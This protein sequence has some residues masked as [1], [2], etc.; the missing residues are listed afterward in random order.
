MLFL[1]SSGELIEIIDIF[2]WNIV[3]MWNCSL[4]ELER[5]NETKDIEA[6]EEEMSGRYVVSLK[7]KSFST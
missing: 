4:L 2:S 1:L 7:L 6:G 5:D 3:V